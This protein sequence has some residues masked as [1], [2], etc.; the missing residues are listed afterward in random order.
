MS[1]FTTE[2]AETTAAIIEH[3]GADADT[4]AEGMSGALWTQLADGGFVTVGVPET[5]GGGGAALGDALAVVTTAARHGAVV[6]LVEHG[7]LA[8]WLAATAGHVLTSEIA[9][10]AKGDAQCSVR[11]HGDNLLF[12]GTV[13]GVPYAADADTLVVILPP[14]PGAGGSSVAVV[15]MS[16]SGADISA[17]TD[18]IGVSYADIIFRDASVAFHG[19]SPVSAT[20]FLQR[21]ALAYA[22]A[23][24]AAAVAV[25]D[26]TVRYASERIQFGRPIAKFQAVQQE[27]A[28]L[29]ART[30]MMEIAVDSAI[31]AHDDPE[32]GRLTTA[33]AKVVT[34]MSA[35]SVA[36]AGH[37]IHGAIGTTSEHSLGRFTTAL[38]SWRD[39]FGSEQFW[40]EDLASRILDDGID[41]WDVVTG[42]RADHDTAPT[43]HRSPA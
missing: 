10:A 23:T 24:A 3:V 30:T 8:A 16:G 14:N 39:R 34:A 26:H 35:H 20:E 29:A 27:L 4:P 13:T 33:A 37:Q 42:T 21:G 17:E 38:W 19:S 2:L 12:D 15:A 32:I 41:V 31:A 22:A 6:P 25:Q 36:A 7:I 18:L 28:Q 9:T 5:A 11:R 43:T 1:E 40:A